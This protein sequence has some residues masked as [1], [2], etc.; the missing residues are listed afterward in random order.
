VNI[1]VWRLHPRGCRV[2]PAEATLGGQA[3]EMAR[4]YCGPYIQA[5]QAGFYLYSPIDADLTWCEGDR[6]DCQP[7]GEF[8]SDDELI[9]IER[10][11][12]NLEELREFIPRTKL[13]LAGSHSEPRHTAQ[14]WTGCIFR[15]PPGWALWLR[16]P[17]NRGYGYPFRVEEA[18]LETSWLWQDIWLNLRFLTA[19]AA[20]CLRRE[21]EPIAQIVPV[22][23]EALNGWKVKPRQFDPDDPEAR[24]V[25]GWWKDYNREKFC[26]ASGADKDSAIYHRRRRLEGR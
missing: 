5:N 15:T 8:W 19:G 18:I 21:S 25:F 26:P 16:S 4:R 13:F 12:P 1:Q 11:N 7:R 20:A 24:E 23:I 22:P 14:L 17:V 6:W 3:P 2:E 10:M 9:E